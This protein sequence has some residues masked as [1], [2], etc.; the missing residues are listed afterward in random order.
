MHLC[1]WSVRLR[2]LLHVRLRNDL[3][4]AIFCP[5]N[6]KQGERLK[7]N[8][9]DI[10]LLAM[11]VAL[12]F[13]I[14]RKLARLDYHQGFRDGMSVG[15]ELQNPKT[16]IPTNDFETERFINKLKNK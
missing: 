7:N 16:K 14:S 3:C 9:L 6:L 4:P 11:I 13:I 15:V 2:S 5:K 8:K 12:L 10:F 1:R